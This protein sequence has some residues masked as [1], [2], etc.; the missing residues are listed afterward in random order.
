[1][2]KS[3]IVQSVKHPE[4]NELVFTICLTEINDLWLVTTLK[5][6]LLNSIL[7]KAILILI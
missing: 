2:T 7:K 1:M 6:S 4:K 3:T 5:D